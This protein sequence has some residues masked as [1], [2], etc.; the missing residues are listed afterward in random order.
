MMNRCKKKTDAEVLL[1]ADTLPP[2]LI[3]RLQRLQYD[4]NS[5]SQIKLSNGVQVPLTVDLGDFS[6]VVRDGQ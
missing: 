4:R 5:G 6:C 3:L 1:K 2:I